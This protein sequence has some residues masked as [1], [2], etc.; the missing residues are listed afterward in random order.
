VKRLKI[1]HLDVALLDGKRKGLPWT[2][3]VDWRL[4]EE[5]K[6]WRLSVGPK[7]WA[8]F[9]EHWGHVSPPRRGRILGLD[10]AWYRRGLE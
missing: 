1:G 4:L 7:L 8:P 2:L 10:W 5:R 9:S 6:R 3:L